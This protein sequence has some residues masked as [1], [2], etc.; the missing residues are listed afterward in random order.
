MFDNFISDS[1][2]N[3]YNHE[4]QSAQAAQVQS[5]PVVT[6]GIYAVSTK[7]ETQPSQSKS[8]NNNR[9]I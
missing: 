1:F 3:R 8:S 4:S 5:Q 2:R 6:K 9:I 7:N